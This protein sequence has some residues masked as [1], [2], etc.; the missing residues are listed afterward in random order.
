MHGLKTSNVDMG[1][2]AGMPHCGCVSGPCAGT[3]HCLARA[4]AQPQPPPNEVAAVQRSPCSL[5]NI[6]GDVIARVADHS[7]AGCCVPDLGSSSHSVP[8]C[9]ADA[10][11][12][13]SRAP[14]IQ[15]QEDGASLGVEVILHLGP[16]QES[17]LPLHRVAVWVSLQM[18]G[19][20]RARRGMAALIAAV[21]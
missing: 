10:G 18:L 8:G 21:W 9:W 2:T 16:A 3:Q 5:T 12:K 4:S 6:L 1:Q 17:R 13:D 19:T 15:A 7:S 11:G 14:G 20:L